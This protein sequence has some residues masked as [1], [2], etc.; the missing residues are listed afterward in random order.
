M[1]VHGFVAKLMMPA[2]SE[3]TA[4][5]TAYNYM[6]VFTGTRNDKKNNMSHKNE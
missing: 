3:F 2:D 6:C 5:E 1:A 4:P